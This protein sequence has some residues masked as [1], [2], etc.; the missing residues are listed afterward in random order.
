M[1][2]LKNFDQIS[3]KT[4]I[5]IIGLIMSFSLLM[6]AYVF[7]VSQGFEDGRLQA[8]KECDPIKIEIAQLKEKLIKARAGNVAQCAQQCADKALSCESI[9]TKKI[10]E[11]LKLCSQ[12]ICGEAVEVKVK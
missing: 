10:E 2:A 12:I 9:C 6:S 3:D 7:G 8:I 4:V 1:I 5:V 11:S